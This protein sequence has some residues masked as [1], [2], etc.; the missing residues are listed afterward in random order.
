MPATEAVQTFSSLA[1]G[2]QPVFIPLGDINGDG[3]DDAI[4]SVRDSVVEELESFEREAR[5]RWI[6]LGP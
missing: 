3:V 1:V 4:V 6:V 2:G 5:V